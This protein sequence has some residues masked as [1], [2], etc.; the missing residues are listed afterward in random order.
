MAIEVTGVGTERALGARVRRQLAEALA[1]LRVAP[2]RAVVTF[3]DDNG[4]KGGRAA[5][6]RI[7]V[8][9][10][11]RP[12]AH[13]EDVA[14][15]RRVAFDAAFASLERQLERHREVDRERR[16]HPKKYYVARRLL[17]VGKEEPHG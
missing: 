16:R 13:G 12:P 1:R 14:A 15:T 4:P 8:G 9:L 10:P 5:R 7:T 11:Y 6:C 3:V 17:A 2:V